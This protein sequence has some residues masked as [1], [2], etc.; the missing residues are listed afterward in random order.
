MTFTQ[1]EIDGADVYYELHN[2]PGGGNGGDYT[3]I[4][5]VAE[6]PDRA[7]EPLW[8][9][10]SDDETVEGFVRHKIGF[11][12]APNE[13]VAFIVCTETGEEYTLTIPS[14]SD[15]SDEVVV[16]RVFCAALRPTDADFTFLNPIK[17]ITVSASTDTVNLQVIALDE[18]KTVTA[19][20][21]ITVT[22]A[23]DFPCV[24]GI[25]YK[26]KTKG[27][28]AEPVPTPPAPVI[29]PP[30]LQHT[31]SFSAP[32]E[33]NYIERTFDAG[34]SFFSRVGIVVRVGGIGIE[35]ITLTTREANKKC[36]RLRISEFYK[37]HSIV[38]DIVGEEDN[39]TIG[40]NETLSSLVTAAGVTR[41]NATSVIEM[42]LPMMQ[43]D[44][45]LTISYK[46]LDV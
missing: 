43:H 24:F 29:E 10:S 30:I 17:N 1:S 35:G 46:N 26:H 19:T 28:V 8:W 15:I 2:N 32:N 38:H 14:F 34:G 20:N 16:H 27:E 13:N 7:G 4:C 41:L 22:H 23:Q 39:L 42:T 36:L 25:I 11:I 40:D 33:V 37:A 6:D 18:Y 45:V 31:F 44:C 3:A 9:Q 21:P 12:R 5:T